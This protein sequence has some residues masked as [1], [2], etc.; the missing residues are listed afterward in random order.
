M[1][2]VVTLE[3][4]SKVILHTISMYDNRPYMIK[5]T[6]SM[7]NENNNIYRATSA[8]LLDKRIKEGL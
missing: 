6:I 7:D 2:A 3:Q 5:Y 8:L 4:K 1:F